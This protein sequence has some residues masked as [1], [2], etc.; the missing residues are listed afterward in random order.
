[1]LK[2]V[3]VATVLSIVSALDVSAAGEGRLYCAANDPT[4]VTSF[5]IEFDEQRGGQLSHFKGGMEIK[6][7]KVPAAFR[8]F[9]LD[10]RMMTQRWTEAGTMSFRLYKYAYTGA[11][12]ETLNVQVVLRPGEGERYAGRYF[13]AANRIP[14]GPDTVQK[15]LAKV[16][17]TL[18]CSRKTDVQTLAN[19]Q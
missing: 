18:T 16:S 1:M 6:D 15:L 7:R 13:L 2:P 11:A 17:G 5:E 14:S 19:Y 10:S 4:I 8:G 9:I 12:L 3:L